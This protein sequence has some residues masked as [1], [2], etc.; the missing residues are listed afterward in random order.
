M[1]EF[2]K[3]I[4]WK[5]SI[6]IIGTIAAI[7]L[8]IYNLIYS[9]RKDQVKID[10][11][12]K[13]AWSIGY[14]PDGKL[15]FKSSKNILNL[16]KCEYIAVDIINQSNFPVVIDEVG[17][18]YKK[19]KDRLVFNPI[20][21]DS[22]DFPRKLESR[23]GFQAFVPIKNLLIEVKSNMISKAFVR[24]QCNNS[25]S[26]SSKALKE[27]VEYKKKFSSNLEQMKSYE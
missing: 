16:E 21:F 1:I 4:D 10:V 19:G 13:V 15:H 20:I 26:G 27:L 5:E 18:T 23:T 17:F 9:R 8:G 14:S 2:L 11:I 3:S 6:H 24:T 12:P 25:A 22:G 7:G